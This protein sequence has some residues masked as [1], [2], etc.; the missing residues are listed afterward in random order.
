MWCTQLLS[1]ERESKS[2]NFFSSS[3]GSISLGSSA[4]TAYKPAGMIVDDAVILTI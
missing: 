3:G 4:V 2:G 1:F